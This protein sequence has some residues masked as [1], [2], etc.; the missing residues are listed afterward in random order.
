MDISKLE[1]LAVS[2]REQDTWLAAVDACDAIFH[3]ASLVPTIQP[4]NAA[5]VIESAKQSTLNVLAAAASHAVNRVVLTSSVTAIFRWNSTG[6]RLHEG[7]IEAYLDRKIAN[8]VIADGLSE[9]TSLSV[10][11]IGT[12]LNDLDVV[13]QLDN[14]TATNL[15]WRP[16]S[17]QEAILSVAKNLIALSVF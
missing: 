2:L 9:L 10:Q 6:P 15:G 8:R 17:P 11:E 7:K 16:R 3:V 13:K 14:P 4:K 5:A 1:W 12:M